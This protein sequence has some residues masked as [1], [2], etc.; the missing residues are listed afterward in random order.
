M[1]SGNY[2]LDVNVTGF[3]PFSESGV[4]IV[5]GTS[6]TLNIPLTIATQ[7]QQVEVTADTRQ[8]DTEPADNGNSVVLSGK[9]LDAL[10]D[11]PDEM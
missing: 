11:D 9:D 7:E 3:T 10:S 8:L 2:T 5:N 4:S 1:P 6:R